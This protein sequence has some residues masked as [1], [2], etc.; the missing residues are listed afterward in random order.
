MDCHCSSPQRTSGTRISTLIKL[1]TDFRPPDRGQ[2]ISC[3]TIV[4][5][6]RNRFSVVRHTLA[7]SFFSLFSGPVPESYDCYLFIYN[8]VSFVASSLSSR[9]WT[10]W[11]CYSDWGCSE[12]FEV[13]CR[14]QFNFHFN[15]PWVQL[16]VICFHAFITHTHH[17][18]FFL[19]F[20]FFF[21]RILDSFFLTWDG[22]V[23]V[24][25]QCQS[26]PHGDLHI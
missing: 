19:G 5:S 7:F 23:G 13:S 16:N 6:D 25:V 8:L 15:F 22:C 9:I 20:F 12:D 4:K 21:L 26:C 11:H 2:C 17:V 14:C 10:K 18:S 1:N 24:T 3:L